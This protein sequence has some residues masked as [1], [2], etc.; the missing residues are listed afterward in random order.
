MLQIVLQRKD[1]TCNIANNAMS[2]SNGV[3][4]ASEPVQQRWQYNECVYPTATI[5]ENNC[6]D[7]QHIWQCN[8]TACNSFDNAMILIVAVL[9]VQW[10]CL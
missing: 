3:E 5:M 1:L 9:T 2:L 10:Y 4:N 8:E 6:D 7:C